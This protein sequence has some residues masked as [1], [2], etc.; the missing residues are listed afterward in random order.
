[1]EL[2]RDASGVRGAC[3]D[4]AQWVSVDREPNIP[5]FTGN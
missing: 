2:S 4:P 5:A 3:V 1:M